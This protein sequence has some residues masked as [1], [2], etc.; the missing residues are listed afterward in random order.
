[1]D[2][3]AKFSPAGNYSISHCKKNLLRCLQRHAKAKADKPV[4][5]RDTHQ[6]GKFKR[7]QILNFPNFARPRTPHVAGRM[8][9]PGK[10]LPG[11]AGGV[12]TGQAMSS[13]LRKPRRGR[14]GSMHTDRWRKRP[15]PHPLGSA[16]LSLSWPWPPGPA[17][18]EAIK[19]PGLHRA[20][21]HSTEGEAVTGSQPNT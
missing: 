5:F 13:Q 17:R 14:G 18:P 7:T 2:T 6:I 8:D 9:H 1:M 16:G 19:H 15:L 21:P 4:D 3:P 20:T 11:G 10:C 12:A